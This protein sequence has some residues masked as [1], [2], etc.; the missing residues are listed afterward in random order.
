MRRNLRVMY[1]ENCSRPVIKYSDYGW[2]TISRFMLEMFCFSVVLL[3]PL[4]VGKI[5]CRSNKTPTV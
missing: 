1:I 4:F 5:V 2:Y 3:P